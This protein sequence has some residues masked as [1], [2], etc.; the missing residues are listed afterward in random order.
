MNHHETMIDLLKRQFG[1]KEIRGIEIGTGGGGLPA[2]LLNLCPNV[3]HLITIDP[4]KHKD[5]VEFEA[6]WEQKD[7]DATREIAYKRLEEYKDRCSIFHMESDTAFELI[8]DPVEFVWI[9]GDHTAEQ[10][11]RDLRF[12]KFVKPRGIIGGHDFGQV[13]LLTEVIKEKYGERIH[14]GE[15]F[16]WFVYL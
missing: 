12:D 5:G 4:W 1:D 10:V 6:A 8:T 3:K 16:T 11:A 7:L 15:D 2:S 9:D 14:T 13:P